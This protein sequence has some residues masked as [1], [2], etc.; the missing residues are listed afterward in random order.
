MVITSYVVFGCIIA[1]RNSL[2]NSIPAAKNAG[3]NQRFCPVSVSRAGL[4]CM[5]KLVDIRYFPDPLG[6]VLAF[7]FQFIG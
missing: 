5:P 4:Q 6:I 1:N 2:V 3:Q 7:K